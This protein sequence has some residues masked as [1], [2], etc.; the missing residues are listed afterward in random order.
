MRGSKRLQILEQQL[1]YL[2]FDSA[3]DVIEPDAKWLGKSR[4]VRR[5]NL[6]LR[7][8]NTRSRQRVHLTETVHWSDSLCIAESQSGQFLLITQTHLA[9]PI[10]ELPEIVRRE[11]R[12]RS[13]GEEKRLYLLAADRLSLAQREQE[14]QAEEMRRCRR[15]STVVDLDQT[16]ADDGEAKMAHGGASVH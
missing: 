12:C 3:L 13:I 6:E 10:Q 8:R 2:P 4:H 14:Q 15:D 16:V 11:C 9:Q 7:E 1:P 5:K